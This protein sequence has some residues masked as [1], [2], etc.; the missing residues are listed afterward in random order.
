VRRT[1]Q[2]DL[3]EGPSDGSLQRGGPAVS[4]ARLRTTSDLLL[5]Q[6]LDHGRT[7]S[8]TLDF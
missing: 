2:D 3:A 7:G 5:R 8:G 1:H 4:R 6:A